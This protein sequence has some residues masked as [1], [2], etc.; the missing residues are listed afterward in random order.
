MQTFII[1]VTGCITGPIFDAGHLRFL[2]ALGTFRVVFGHMM[3]SLAQEYWQALL[4]QAFAIGLGAGCLYVPSVAVLPQYF[5]TRMVTAMGLA[6]SRSSL[7]GIIY[8]IMFNRLLDQV[9]FPWAVRIIAFLALA[10]LLVPLTTMKLRNRPPAKRSIFDKTAFTDVSFAAYMVFGFVG[11]L[12]LLIPFFYIPFTSEARNFASQELSFYLLPMLNAA[13]IF[14]RIIP[15]MIADQIGPLNMLVPT[16]TM[17]AV[18]AY[19]AVPVH[20]FAGM[21]CIAVFYGFWSGAYIA[22]PPAI[23]V[24]LT[25]PDKRHLIGTRMGMGF[26]LMG[27]GGLIGSPVAGAIAGPTNDFT[28]VYVWTGTT[29][30]A[31]A[32]GFLGVRILRVGT[33]IWTV[34]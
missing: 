10:I 14:G 29:L 21:V 20:N 7:G 2:L 28:G 13:S 17:T 30:A 1:L 23:F 18:V 16:A 22:L 12:G 9:G 34:V 5:T 24:R 33:A 15:A 31:A 3:L 25:P 8:P 27:V 26:T 4:A 19:S 6:V 11:Y 32:L